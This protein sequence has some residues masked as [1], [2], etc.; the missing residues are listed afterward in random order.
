MNSFSDFRCYNSSVETAFKSWMDMHIFNG[1]GH[2]CKKYGETHTGS[3][4][5]KGMLELAVLRA[6]FYDFKRGSRFQVLEKAF[7]Q[8]WRHIQKA[9]SRENATLT[10]VVGVICFGGR[11]IAV[12]KDKERLKSQ[13]LEDSY[14]IFKLHGLIICL[15]IAFFS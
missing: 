12:L 10:S 1:C 5:K 6:G 9:D 4:T 7:P 15:I 13:V 14:S 2:R 11:S 8:I 3:F